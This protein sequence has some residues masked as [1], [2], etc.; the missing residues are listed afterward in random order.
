MFRQAQLNHLQQRKDR[1]VIDADT[2]ITDIDVLSSGQKFRLASTA[3][4]YHGRP[5]SCEQLLA[6]MEAAD[7]DM[8]LAWQNP[9]ATEYTD[10]PDQNYEHLWKANL[11]I[12]D[13]AWRYPDRIIPAGWTDPLALG[14]DLSVEL[15]RRC[16]S[17]LGF[18]IVKMNPAQNGFPIDDARV[19][20]VLESIAEQGAVP[21]FHYGAD[22][23][24]TTP[25]AFER[26][27]CCYPSVPI[28]GVHMGGGGAS[29]LEAEQT[30]QKSR[31]L[32]L[33]HPNVRFILS[34]KRDVHME[35]DLISYTAAGEPFS[36]NLYCG[37][38][39]PYGKVAWNFGGFRGLFATLRKTSSHS[40][41]RIRSNPGLFSREVEAGY[42]GGNL[43][44]LIIGIYSNRF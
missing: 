43:A 26:V 17:E 37:S 7:V 34:A 2:H 11:Y 8:A 19:F 44:T 28:I 3:D 20:K 14:L 6:E 30:Y 33:L 13:C 38:D 32:G 9:A 27:V 39:A 4:Y 41:I 10:S 31:E 24:Y 25:E 36:R 23:R 29:Y 21:A 1:L 22:T 40:D 42:L 5:I 15:A 18:P 16:V 12:A 35:S